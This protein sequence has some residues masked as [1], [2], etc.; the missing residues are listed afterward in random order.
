MTE[1]SL[2]SYLKARFRGYSDAIGADDDLAGVVD[3]LGLFELVEFIE[4]TAGVT[5][6][7]ID[8]R[9]ARF[10]TIRNILALVG[11]QSPGGRAITR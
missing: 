4:Q 11:E 9:P 7:I 8:F 2:R 10:S 6:P 3:S 5:V 1:A